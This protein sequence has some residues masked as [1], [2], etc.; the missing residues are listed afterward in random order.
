ML[1]DTQMPDWE[2]RLTRAE[3]VDAAV[4]R[5]YRAIREVDLL[6]S[7][8]STGAEQALPAE[9]VRWTHG[10]PSRPRFETSGFEGLPAKGFQV[11]ADNGSTEL[12]LGFIGRWWQDNYGRA[13]W[14]PADLP[15]FDQPGFGVGAWSLTV[16]GY[17][18]R[19]CALVTEV[20]LRCTDP[21]ARQALGNYFALTSPLITAMGRPML[22][23]IRQAAERSTGSRDGPRHLDGRPARL[24][25]CR[26]AVGPDHDRT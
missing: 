21:A 11:V 14:T 4:D 18:D 2:Q 10:S 6:R 20:R 5:T 25:E 12:V 1:I 19:G 7:S 22:R 16:L 15:T 24:G 17:G 26:P 13:N 23:L 9:F 3:P 8:L